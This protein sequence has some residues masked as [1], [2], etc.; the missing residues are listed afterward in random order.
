MKRVENHKNNYEECKE[1]TEEH[2]REVKNKEK[3]KVRRRAKKT[4]TL[5]SKENYN[6][7]EQRITTGNERE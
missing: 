1:E 7:K 5:K 2:E 3:N 6:F 4:T